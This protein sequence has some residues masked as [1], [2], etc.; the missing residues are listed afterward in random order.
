MYLFIIGAS[1]GL[2]TAH[3]AALVILQL[4]VQSWFYACRVEQFYQK[5]YTLNF[6]PCFYSKK[7]QVIQT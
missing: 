7:E 2:D 1:W 5:F 4:I 3:I 6:K